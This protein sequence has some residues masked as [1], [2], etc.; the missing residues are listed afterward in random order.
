V[1]VTATLAGGL[2]A[3][4]VVETI[5]AV[6]PAGVDSKTRTDRAD[7]TGKD[8]EKVRRFVDAAKLTR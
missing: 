2:A 1:S 3:G 4:N 8:L 7:G 6:R 5:A